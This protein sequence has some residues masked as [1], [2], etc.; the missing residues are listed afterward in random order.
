MPTVAWLRGGSGATVAHRAMAVAAV[1]MAGWLAVPDVFAAEPAPSAVATREEG[2]MSMQVGEVRVLKAPK[3]ARVVVGDGHVLRALTTDENEVIVFARNE[4]FSALGLWARDGT[5][6]Q[7]R[8]Q[9]APEGAKRAQEELRSLL[10]RIPG[11]SV[12]VVGEKLVVEGDNLGEDDRARIAALARQ[13]PQ[14]VN[15]TGQVGWDD[16]VLLDVQVVEVP[17]SRLRELGVRWG[18]AHDGAAYFGAAWD[19]GSAGLVQRPGAPPLAYPLNPGT[20]ATY[21]GVNA[22]WSA[23]LSL[24]EQQGQAVVLA[25]PQLLARSGATAEFHAGGE[26]PYSSVTSD[27]KPRTEFKPYGVQLRITPQVE[28]N[29]TVRS[30]IEVEVSAVDQALS[31]PSGPSLKTR[32]A[33]TEFN[34]RSGETLV[35]AGFLS[36]SVGW[37]QDGLPGLADI[38]LVGSLFGAKRSSHIETELAIFVTPSVVAGDHPDLRDRVRRGKDL[39][40]TSFPDAPWINTPLQARQGLPHPVSAPDDAGWRPYGNGTQWAPDDDVAASTSRMGK[41]AF[42]LTE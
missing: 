6:R 30:R 12:V 40:G 26:V 42:E 20:W 41:N 29:G 14:L 28:R 21:A 22:L 27:G 13:Y 19:G 35:L 15:L 4:G 24:M 37:H 7:L 39:L 9:V 18:A 36:R 23:R 2:S 34:V 16:M 10:A 3:I 17:R 25:Q 1:W 32:R 11:A 31:A 38:P 5:R 8:V 33:A